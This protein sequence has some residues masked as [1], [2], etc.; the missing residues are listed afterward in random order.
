MRSLRSWPRPCENGPSTARAIVSENLGRLG[1]TLEKDGLASCPC[2]GIDLQF[3]VERLAMAYARQRR[4]HQVVA[5]TSGLMRLRNCDCG[6]NRNDDERLF[7]DRLEMSWERSRFRCTS[8]P[9]TAVWNCF[10][11]YV[12]SRLYEVSVNCDRGERRWDRASRRD[13]VRPLFSR[14]VRPQS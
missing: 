14:E 2:Q 3:D 4:R 8:A 10:S 6:K 9:V 12:S 1:Q 5:R 7:V 13:R 11:R